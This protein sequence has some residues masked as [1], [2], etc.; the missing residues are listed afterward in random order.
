MIR[1]PPRSTLFPYTTLFRSSGWNHQEPANVRNHVA[2]VGGGAGAL[3][4]PRKALR[5]Q[6][7]A[8]VAAGF[9]LRSERYRAC[10]SLQPGDGAGG[11]VQRGALEGHWGHRTRTDS[12][13]RHGNGRGIAVSRL[14]F[15]LRLVRPKSSPPWKRLG[16]Y[17]PPS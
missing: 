9:G 16:C 15:L 5:P 11:S 17:L 10:G 6:R 2:A 8:F 1:R 13:A 3:A 12:A 7:S 4:G 14:I